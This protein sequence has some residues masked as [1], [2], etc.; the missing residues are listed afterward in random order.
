MIKRA[1][2][3]QLIDLAQQLLLTNPKQFRKVIAIL[4]DTVLKT[5]KAEKEVTT[6]R[7]GPKINLFIFLVI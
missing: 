5:I 6:D 2:N 1:S 3:A 7:M 4:G